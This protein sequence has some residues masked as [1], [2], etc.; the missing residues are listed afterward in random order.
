[1]S[2][3]NPFRTL[4]GRLVLVT[5]AAIALSHVA[6]SML[7]AHER[8]DSLRRLAETIIAER[9]A[10]VADRLRSAPSADRA[11][12]ARNA[13]DFVVRYRLTAEAP[14]TSNE[15]QAGARVARLVSESL[16][17]VRAYG[18][19][20]VV[21]RTV[22]AAWRP[23]PDHHPP[24]PPPDGDATAFDVL[25][26]DRP[27]EPGTR[28]FVLRGSA[29][30]EERRHGDTAFTRHVRATE[31]TVAIELGPASWLVAR[32]RLP[33]GRP[34][35][36]AYYAGA[37]ASMLAVALGA[38][39][40]AAQIARPLA[41][42]GAAAQRLGAG[43]FSATAPL[44]GPNDVRR[45]SAAFNDMASRLG[46]QIGRQ[47]QML[48]ALSHDLRTPITALRLRAELLDDETLRA[49]MLAQL[50]EM[51]KL[52]EEA[53]ALARA[54]ASDE[55]RERVDLGDIARTLIA[56]LQEL[57]VAV[58]AGDIAAIA[59][60]YRPAEIAR[61]I[62]N[63]IENGGRHGGGCAV[64][65]RSDAQ[66]AIVE[67]LDEGPG[68]PEDVAARVREPFFRADTAR[69][70]GGGAGLGLA[71]VQAIADGHGGELVLEN[72]TPRGLRAALIL[73]LG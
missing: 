66:R 22:R 51:E 26:D 34:L 17:G 25:I 62:R 49:K 71:I 37:I 35:T 5:I 43:D 31:A 41:K 11:V 38:I 8:S 55:A 36:I 19:A 3:F 20:R 1:V 63:L 32:T 72:R 24:G 23:R 57:G 2:W 18:R 58:T 69:S 14:F 10:A 46:R 60:S 70:R 4:A 13:S 65:V 40:V 45:A 27:P 15:G 52:T 6:V 12:I 59:V 9:I 7:F 48:W 21:D 64:S 42:L 29:G 67:V 73:P 30:D 28:A 53:L 56:E 54:G 47:R 68:L 50:A 16:D 61:A 33:A 39:F 44:D